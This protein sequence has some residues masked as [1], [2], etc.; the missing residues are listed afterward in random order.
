M[1]DQLIHYLCA[2]RAECW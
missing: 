1:K 2:L